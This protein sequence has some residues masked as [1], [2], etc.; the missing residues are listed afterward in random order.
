[1]I[2]SLTQWWL[3]IWFVALMITNLTGKSLNETQCFTVLPCLTFHFCNF[4]FKQRYLLSSL[5]NWKF[6][7]VI[8]FRHFLPYKPFLTF[9]EKTA[10]ELWAICL[11]LGKALN[12]ARLS[13]LSA[14]LARYQGLRVAHIRPQQWDM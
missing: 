6:D 2:K 13:F 10:V 3:D 5:N 9:Q 4:A 14:N 11:N 12:Q 7:F 8:V 1:M